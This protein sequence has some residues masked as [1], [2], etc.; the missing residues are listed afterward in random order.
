M[1]KLY[2]NISLLLFFSIAFS[3][4]DR[5][6]MP[7]SGPTPT[8][9]LGTP[10]EFELK[11]GL[12]V[13]MVENHKLPR[14][15]ASLLID[16]PPKIGSSKNGIYSLTSSMLGKG[17]QSITKDTF[18][19]E[20]DFLG[21]TLSVNAEGAYASSLSRFFPK[22]LEMMA[23]GALN[24][25]FSA[26]EFDK[27][28]TKTL[29][30]IKSNSKSVTA[31]ARRVESVLAY[32]K[33]HPSGKF[34][35]E[36]SINNISFED[37]KKYYKENFIPNNSY[38]VIIGDFNPNETR[39]MIRNL[40]SGWKKGELNTS[41]WKIPSDINELSINFIDVSNAIQSEIVYQNLVDISMNHPD[42]FPVIVSNKILGG[43]P[44]NRLE[45]QI[46]E[47]KGYTYAARSSIGSS[48]YTK[49]R[50]RASTST[51]FQV[52][53]SA[54]VELL[55]E[56]KKIKTIN[57]S[58]K[59]LSD[60]KAKYVGNFVLSS[61]SPST[62]ANY[63]L[64]IKTQSLDKDFYKNYLS[65]INKVSKEDIIRVSKKYFQ[66]DKGQII[67]TG[68]GSEL[69]NKLEK[70]SFENKIIPILFF[71]KYGNQ[72]EKPILNKKIS[73][74]VN[75]KTIFENYLN[76]IGGLDE[77]NKIKSI[78]TI[79][80]V[81]IQN[82]PFSPTAEIKQK[83]PNLNSLVMTVEGMGTLM[84]QKFDG[85]NGYIEQMGQKIPFEEDQINSEKEKLGLFEET[86]LDSN[87]MEIISLNP[88]DG[89][90]LYKI[91]VNGKSFRYYD[92]A[93]NLLI[94]KEETVNVAGNEITSITKYSN[95]KEIE[96][97]LFPY[98]REITSGPQTVVFEISSIKFNEEIDDSF[99][100]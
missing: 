98:K 97:V 74:E 41:N 4:V 32:G 30:G 46:R 79:A 93:T 31:I 13:L 25:L 86:Y 95:Y 94:I 67:I 70:I 100:K 61:E 11:N 5:S 58:D 2:L 62:I 27:E 36:E 12:K 52:T 60:V 72:V 69:I 83:H 23:D 85:E 65:N 26:E 6:K 87:K 80:T 49:S 1:K 42:Y 68:K 89:K 75:V 76:A 57:V 71:D 54:V 82:A 10:I 48:K 84:S 53:D 22:V 44:E 18:I 78:S 14:V 66:I 56:I 88:I 29:E 35:S 90:D 20:I 15:S 16:N 92:A 64:N 38:L 17:S 40:F 77:I 43:G 45:K 59:E 33:D 39:K 24:P 9:E 21:A 47:T 37:V 73:K 81:K 91:K 19:E 7:V 34:I 63:A 99:F 50:F 51:R 55:N 28:K 8:I 96:G 3:Q